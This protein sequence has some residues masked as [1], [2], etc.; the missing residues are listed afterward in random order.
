MFAATVVIH[1]LVCFGDFALAN[2]GRMGDQ[3]K[4]LSTGDQIQQVN[5]GDSTTGGFH[6]FEFH[7]GSANTL[8]KILLLIAVLAL[9]YLWIRRKYRKAAQRLRGQ[10]HPMMG[11]IAAALT[12]AAGHQ[13]LGPAYPMSVLPQNNRVNSNQQRGEE[14][15]DVER[16]RRFCPRS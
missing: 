2:N 8:T 1:F 9:A 15:E 5:A 14:D 16:G 13:I 6:I 11:D 4:V 7:E 3:K 12:Q 10:H